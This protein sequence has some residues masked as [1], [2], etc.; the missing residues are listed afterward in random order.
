MNVTEAQQIRSRLQLA[1]FIDKIR[2]EA[3]ANPERVE[4]VRIEDYLE[5]MSAYLRDFPGLVKNGAWDAS[6][7]D[8]TWALFAAVLAGAAIYE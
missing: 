3:S 4:N 8:P 7:D 2:A 5:A 1:E 6:A